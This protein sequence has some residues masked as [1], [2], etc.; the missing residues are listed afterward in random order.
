MELRGLVPQM[1]RGE[2]E[3]IKKKHYCRLS[4]EGGLPFHDTALSEKVQERRERRIQKE[5]KR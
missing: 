2:R 1:G 3:R 5:V 4:P